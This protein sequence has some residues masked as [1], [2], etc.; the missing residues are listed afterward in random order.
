MHRRDFLSR[1]AIGTV[2]I[3]A[4]PRLLGAQGTPSDSGAAPVQ[5]TTSNLFDMNQEAAKTV[6]R[7]P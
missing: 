7:P 3:G 4:A 2:A 5:G 1:L 6:R